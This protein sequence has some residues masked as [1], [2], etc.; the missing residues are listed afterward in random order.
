MIILQLI[1]EFP[2]K[3]YQKTTKI[4]YFS[5]VL[6]KFL[7]F[8]IFKTHSYLVYNFY[9]NLCKYLNNISYLYLKK[10]RRKKNM[11]LNNSFPIFIS[12]IFKSS[13]KMLM[14][15]IVKRKTKKVQLFKTLFQHYFSINLSEIS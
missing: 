8:P 12:P 11:L 10:K 3:W 6:R 14:I 2:M 15:L 13:T 7:S 4:L 9:S 1:R 5:K